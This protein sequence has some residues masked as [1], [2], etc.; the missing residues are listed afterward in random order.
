M[1]MASRTIEEFMKPD[2]PLGEEIVW[3]QSGSLLPLRW[4]SGGVFPIIQYRNHYWAMF[5]FRDINPIGLNIANGASENKKEYKEIHR[6]MGREFSEETILFQS[7][8][9]PDSNVIH[10]KFSIDC[11][12]MSSS[13][14]ISDYFN[15]DFSK[16]HNTLREVHDKVHIQT[17]KYSQGRPIRPINTPFRIE[18]TYHAAD[19]TRIEKAP[20]IRNAV[21]TINPFEFGVEIV[22]LYKFTLFDNDVIIDGEYDLGRNYLIRQPVILLRMDFLKKI[23]IKNNNSIGLYNTET[24]C[25]ILPE[26]PIESIKFFLD[27][28][29]L[30]KNRLKNIADELQNKDIKQTF[31]MDNLKYEENRI[32]KWLNDYEKMFNFDDK[33]EVNDIKLRTLCPVSWK[34]LEIIFLHNINYQI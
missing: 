17:T 20:Y 28:I 9:F 31:E 32:K 11:Y 30:R 1:E 26:I 2:T 3:G 6:L 23:F 5:F 33:T 14:A 7:H 29:P 34:I 22:W 21:F 4:V 18:L 12:D 19:L 15:E 10:Q 25:K 27:D 13:S 24:D 16:E 8:P